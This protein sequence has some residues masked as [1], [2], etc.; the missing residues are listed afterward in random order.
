MASEGDYKVHAIAV[1]NEKFDATAKKCPE[2]AAPTVSLPIAN[3]STLGERWPGGEALASSSSTG[4]TE[5]PTAKDY[6]ASILSTTIVYVPS[7]DPTVNHRILVEIAQYAR[8]LEERL[9]TIQ[10]S[11][12]TS[13]S[14]NDNL[15]STAE[16]V[17][18]AT[19]EK[20]LQIG[21]LTRTTSD[22]TAMDRFFGRSSGLQFTKAAISRIR[23][24]PSSL[25]GIRR[26][27]F[28]DIQP[29]QWQKLTIEASRQIFPPDDLLESLTKIYFE[30]I[31]PILNILHFPTFHHS[32]LNGLHLQSPDFGS[33]VLV[34]PLSTVA[35]GN[36]SSSSFSGRPS[37]TKLSDFD[38][39]L[40]LACDE[41]YWETPNAMQ[42]EGKPSTSAYMP[43]YLQLM[44]IFGR[45]Q[46]AV[47]TRIPEEIVQLE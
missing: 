23:G 27:V 30:Q 10:L 1:G 19:T 24:N 28:W 26:P 8:S 32:L 16:G 37:I 7:Q 40:P 45:I 31:N 22:S 25:V 42:P 6:I 17:T 15:S 43:V 29:Q 9:A 18:S 21:D 33:V 4:S 46:R 38:I 41:E 34:G 2:D 11:Q 39:E 5:T 44:L 14:P 13:R 20:Y 3:A 12:T 47:E 36:G 35:V